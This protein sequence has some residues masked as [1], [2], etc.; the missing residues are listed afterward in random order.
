MNGERWAKQ[1][2]LIASNVNERISGVVWEESARQAR[3][4]LEIVGG[5]KERNNV[6]EG[7]KVVAINVLA[8]AGYGLR[9]SWNGHDE[10]VSAEKNEL[11]Q[12]RQEGMALNYIEATR[13]AVDHVLEVAVLPAWL[14]TLSWMPKG[15][16]RIGHAITEFP[17]HTK[18]ML[19][20]E[21][22]KPSEKVNLL[23]ML[24]KE[25]DSQV[26][27]SEEKGEKQI[28]TGAGLSED[29]IMGNLFVFTAAGF[30]TT[31]NTMAYAMV[32]LAAYPH[33]QEWL[34]EEIDEVLEGKSEDLSYSDIFPR[35]IRMLA[36]MQETLRVYSPLTHIA[37]MAGSD[38]TMSSS[39]DGPSY[40]VPK[41]T[42]IYINVSA[43]HMNPDVYGLDASEFRPSR[44]ISSQEEKE[45][46]V[47]VEQGA[48]LPWSAGPRNCPGYKMSQVEFVSVFVTIFRR[49]RVE[50]VRQVGETAEQASKR[51][52]ASTED[53]QS[54][55]TLQMNHP[56]DVVLRFVKR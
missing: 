39:A 9:S 3:E 15:L 24:V 42:I 13:L 7:L 53:S 28:G 22:Q 38:L 6:A 25:S 29:E 37:K 33:L 4:M 46:L 35:L 52:V 11:W 10:E 31:A 54:R 23:S 19:E 40:F 16:Q 43:T 48:F 55:L 21:R 49:F 1:R 12:S 30:D 18:G 36:L 41:D 26:S 56:K 5:G 32:I 51:V 44:W 8:R 47:R 34:C 27:T 50:V 14:C 2:K 45:S 17:V 20:R